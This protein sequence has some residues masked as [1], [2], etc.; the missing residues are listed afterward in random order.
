MQTS[1]A[2]RFHASVVLLTISST[3][4]K[5]PSS[6][7]KSL[8]KAQ[9]PHFLMQTLV[10]LIFLFTTYVTRSP[11]EHFLS[12]SATILIAFIS[13][14]RESNNS[15]ACLTEISFESRASFNIWATT[16]SIFFNIPS[17][18]DFNSSNPPL[19]VHLNRKSLLYISTN[20]RV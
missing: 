6:F 13:G 4:R 12:M 8:L 5:Y 14:P 20:C 15:T 17:N 16:G 1:V 7:L 19:Q 10:K 11:T 18:I 2:P 3:G 9:N